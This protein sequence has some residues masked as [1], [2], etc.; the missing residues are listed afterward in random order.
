MEKKKK[1]IDISVGI[2]TSFPVWP[3]DP[4]LELEQVSSIQEGEDANVSRLAMSVHSGTHV[5]APFHFVDGG[6]TVEALNLNWLI[7]A[8]LV[9]EVPE[10]IQAISA[11]WLKNINIPKGTIRVLFKTSNVKYWQE[12][13][14]VFHK[15]FVALDAEGAAYLVSKGIKLVGI[16][17]FSVASYY[18][19][20]P[21]HQ[22]LLKAGII[23]VE[24]LNLSNV[25][26]GVYD[27]VCMPLKLMGCDGA[28]ARCVLVCYEE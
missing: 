13:P 4:I 3:G 20:V 11:A 26:P 18:D 27:L 23:I 19:G 6:K 7:G 14:L 25:E 15:D 5:D 21:T 17:Y 28:P 24:T 12:K 9:I 2:D 10:E 16:D 1:I 22:I 8:V